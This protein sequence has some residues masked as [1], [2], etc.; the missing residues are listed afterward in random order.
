MG[1]S[2]PSAL[3]ELRANEASDEV[4][5]AV[6]EEVWAIVERSRIAADVD[7]DL[8]VCDFEQTSP[9]LSGSRYATDAAKA[10]PA[11][12]LV[13]VSERFLLETE[14]AVRAFEASGPL[15]ACPYLRS[16]EDLFALTDRIGSDPRRQVH[17]LRGLTA[18]AA[19]NERR[20]R[21]A[22][23]GLYLF[24]VSHEIG[25]LAG[26]RADA[27][28]TT[29]VDP[30]EPLEHRLANAVVKLRR[31]A[32]EF[33]GLGFDLPGGERALQPGDEIEQASAALRVR[34]E[35]LETNHRIWFE[36]ETA[37]DELGTRLVLE[38]LD[39]LARTSKEDADEAMYRL[40]RG[41]F[42][43]AMY[44]WYRDLRAFSRGL[45]DGSFANTQQLALVMSQ[46]REQYIRAASLFGEVHRFTLLRAERLI[47][48]AIGARSRVYA[49]DGAVDLAE[50]QVQPEDDA[51]RRRVAY[52]YEAVSRDYLLRSLM[53]TAV[54]IAYVGAST[55][56]ILETDRRR[57]TSQV[58]LML[59]ESVAAALER[60]QRMGLGVKRPDGVSQT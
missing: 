13:V 18:G 5:L 2:E 41:V 27:N 8:L 14:A 16:D 53:D 29:F 54:K 46:Q 52:L 26:G 51:G 4:T 40:V 28:F 50:L 9:R 37:A 22:L 36:E 17:R 49:E 58:F 38:H 48:A 45:P 19:E 60:I 33:A 57:G 1:D 44:S 32:E 34:L 59:F 11:E 39:G 35:R 43:A 30:D 24:F 23:A 42:A 25:H 10:L 7:I 47:E 56:W 12:G 6:L 15:A 20:V 31:H 55:A 21:D 3:A